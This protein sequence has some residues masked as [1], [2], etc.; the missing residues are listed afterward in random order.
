MGTS[1][2]T[3]RSSVAAALLGLVA[4]I[5]G[6]SIGHLAA[7]FTEPATSPVLAIGSAVIDA[8]PTP[9]KEW[10]IARFGTA[11]KT[12]LL[13][14]VLL[15]VAV[16]AA[17]GGLLARR[18]RA[19]GVGVLLAMTVAAGWAVMH[20]PTATTGDLLPTVVT[21]VTGIAVLLGLFHLATRADAAA[22]PAAGSQASSPGLSRRT[23]LL[24]SGAVVVGSAVAGWWGQQKVRLA[25]LIDK[26][27]L[28]QAFTR[29][30][31]A[32]AGLEAQIPEVSSLITSNQDFYRV[33]VNLSLPIVAPDDWTLTVN[34]QVENPFEITFDELL[35]MPMVEHDVTL[36]C[37][38]NEVGGGYVGTA[39]WLG[40]PVASLLERAGVKGG[41]QVLST[42]QDGFTLSTPLLALQD[43]RMALVAVG[44]NGEPLPAA[45]GF[46]A[47][48]V[49][50]G[51]YGYVGSTK[52]VRTL[53]VTSYAEQTAYWTERGWAEQGPIKLSS[54]IDTP[55]ALAKVK[56]GTVPVAG[57]AW[58]Q[59]VGIR[60]VQLRIDG[61]AWQTARLGPSIGIDS[62]RQ[63]WFPWEATAGLHSLEVRAVDLAGTV[64]TAQR[65]APFPNG[66]SGVQQL[67]VTVE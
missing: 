27:Q 54:R 51:L 25:E 16:L 42:A 67:Q 10:A 61:G 1:S 11:D 29:L 20:R 49:T 62:W 44:M 55:A 7:G 66:S 40:V 8:T 58:A 5:A 38:S 23:L 39:R 19:A 13:G 26:V 6:T 48:L 4:V 41:D 15:G 65:A 30:P 53:T 17:L 63:W 60:E 56:A 45:H 22:D 64:Q 18:H 9:V 31:P 52:W 46:P 2:H 57:V 59:H 47:R 36:T 37:V 28:P 24:T 43:G 14:S 12:I 33:D 3:P 35:A 21:A 32:P 34:G 50:P